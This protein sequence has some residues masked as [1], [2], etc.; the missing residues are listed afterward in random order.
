M[1]SSSNVARRAAPHLLRVMRGVSGASWSYLPPITLCTT[2]AR[3]PPWQPS[4]ARRLC[5]CLEAT[6]AFHTCLS[7]SRSTFL[8]NTK[9]ATLC[10]LYLTVHHSHHSPAYTC[11]PG[12]RLTIE[13]P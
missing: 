11:P 8:H 6:C 13:T 3:P 2:W 12:P 9:L 4:A 1:A 5:R 10:S 7:H